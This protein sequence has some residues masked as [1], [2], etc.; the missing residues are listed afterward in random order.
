MPSSTWTAGFARDSVHQVKRKLLLLFLCAQIITLRTSTSTSAAYL[1]SEL[2]T[3]QI[4]LLL[5]IINN[6]IVMYGNKLKVKLYLQAFQLRT[7]R[8]VTP[9]IACSHRL[10]ERVSVQSVPCHCFKNLSLKITRRNKFSKNHK[11]VE[12][13][14]STCFITYKKRHSNICFFKTNP[15]FVEQVCL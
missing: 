11:P 8:L 7:R 15:V 14:C 3:L 12:Q 2:H 10:E 5:N 6:L 9:D 13:E 1:F 4:K